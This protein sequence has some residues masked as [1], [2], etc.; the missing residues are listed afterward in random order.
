[1]TLEEA[2]NKIEI[3]EKLLECIHPALFIYEDQ[4]FVKVGFD[5][6]ALTPDVKYKVYELDYFKERSDEKE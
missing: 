4:I 2:L 1:M 6:F 5:F 3:Y